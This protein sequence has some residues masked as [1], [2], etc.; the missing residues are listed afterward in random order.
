MKRH[1]TEELLARLARISRRRAGGAG[2]LPLPDIEVASFGIGFADAHLFCVLMCEQMVESLRSGDEAEIFHH[3]FTLREEDQPSFQPSPPEHILPWLEEHGY[4]DEARIVTYK[5]VVRGLI[6]D[7]LSFLD[8]AFACSRRTAM[9]ATTIGEWIGAE[10]LYELRYD[11]QSAIGF[12][13]TWQQATHLIT[14]MAGMATEEKNF[15]FIFSHDKARRSRWRGFYAVLPILLFH[16]AGGVAATHV[17]AASRCRFYADPIH[18]RTRPVDA[19]RRL[20]PYA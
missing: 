3:N 13:R 10:F 11:K 16:A 2:T 17:L 9:E 8:V 18:R 1:R 4:H 14:T 6:A 12:E 7:M 19:K 15:N 20:R 5:A